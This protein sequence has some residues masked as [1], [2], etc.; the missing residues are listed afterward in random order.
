MM[1]YYAY[2]IHLDSLKFQRHIVLFKH[3]QEGTFTIWVCSLCYL[4]Y[5]TDTDLFQNLKYIL[6]RDS[7]DFFLSES[8]ILNN[9]H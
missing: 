8:T 3:K 5:I 6:F 1:Q 2:T 7:F 9:I 4:L